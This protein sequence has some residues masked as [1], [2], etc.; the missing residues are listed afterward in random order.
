LA[1][2]GWMADQF[3][4]TRWSVVLAAAENSPDAG[5]A[6]LEAICRT[7]WRPL[8]AYA[9]RWGLSLEDAED[10]VQGFFASIVSSG[11][12][13]NVR[14]GNGRFRAWLL[15]GMKHHMLDERA[16]AVVLKRGGADRI[17]LPLDATDADGI[18][19]QAVA[20]SDSPDK[21]FDRAWALTLMA[22]ARGRL[23][24]ECE[25]SGKARIFDVVFPQAT[26]PALD[27]YDQ[28]AERLGLSESGARSV[29]HRLR[30]RW[31]DLIRDEVAQTVSSREALEGEL[32]SLKAALRG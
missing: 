12:I 32:A 15:S 18:C 2:V 1:I 27:N 25:A 28:M 17:C 29:A 24:E 13:R 4:T 22:K 7:Y 9:R 30:L 10:S 16:K 23:R 14:Q 6:A 3:L 11:S 5:D 31:R 20:S 26:H 8:F 19:L 21:A